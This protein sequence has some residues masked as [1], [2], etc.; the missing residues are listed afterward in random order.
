MRI[1]RSEGGAC[2]RCK[3]LKKQVGLNESPLRYNITL[4]DCSVTKDYHVR[5]APLE[6]IQN[7][8]S[9]NVSEGDYRIE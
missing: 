9:L 5:H 3:I 1:L 8:G 7:Y 6:I 4:K 2:W